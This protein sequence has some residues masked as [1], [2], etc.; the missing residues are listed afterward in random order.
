MVPA[1]DQDPG[2]AAGGHVRSRTW[3]DDAGN[4]RSQNVKWLFNDLGA[5]AVAGRVY[6]VRYNA[7]GNQNPSIATIAVAPTDTP[8]LLC[9]ALSATA[10][11]TWDWFCVEGFVEAL[12]EGTTDVTKGDYLAADD[13]IITTY[14][15]IKENTTTRTKNSF[16]IYQDD[17]DQ[18]TDGAETARLIYMFGTE[19]EILT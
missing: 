11:Q 1:L 4:V 3:Y 14:G 5:A 2:S 8:E 7:E 6:V 12:V 10:D 19:V 13:D 16:A 18:T 17:T 9:V 15:G